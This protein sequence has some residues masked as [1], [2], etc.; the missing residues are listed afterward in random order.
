LGQPQ[1][2]APAPPSDALQ[3]TTPQGTV[4]GFV[5]A[6]TRQDY[7][8]AAKYLNTPLDGQA[9]E[10]LATQLSAVLDYGL[11][12]DVSRISNQ[13]EGWLTDN[14]P[15]GRDR[16]GVVTIPSGTLDVEVERVRRGTELIWLFSAQTVRSIPVAYREIRRSKLAL[17]LPNWLM[18]PVW[19]SIALWQWLALAIGVV[20]AGAVATALRRVILPLVRRV[21]GRLAEP[22][23][24]R[25]IQSLASPIRALVALGLMEFTVAILDLPLVARALWEIWGSKLLT[26]AIV[27]LFLRMVRVLGTL[28]A[29]RLERSGTPDSTALVRLMQRTISLLAICIAAVVLLKNAGVNVT[30]L[31]A[32]LGVGGIA[33][34]FAAQKTLENLF[35]GVAL[36]FDKSLRVGDVCRIDKHLGTI[37]DIGLRSTRLRTFER[38]MVTI[39]N[40][41]LSAVSVENLGV[42]DKMLFRHLLS[43]RRDCSLDQLKE[44]LDGIRSLLSDSQFVENGSWRVRFVQL[45]S[46]SLDIEIFACIMTV[47]YIHF[48][49]IQEE[50]LIRILKLV[51][52]SGTEVAV[53]SQVIYLNRQ[54]TSERGHAAGS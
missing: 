17:H 38:A 10:E 33:V 7:A 20:F 16:I 47:D 1:P 3:R 29:R 26:I 19:L 48:L 35:G 41:H 46:S 37:E 28:I 24:D 13:P 43:L 51:A 22:G 2:V 42:R 54:G 31:L 53:P 30:A 39:P 21:V 49:E 34:A 40:G 36:I 25:L 5:R 9:A 32:G 12:A 18:K 8:T 4:V 15:V 45:G 6:A 23:D 44:I 50:M 52:E 11:P 14:L 27:W